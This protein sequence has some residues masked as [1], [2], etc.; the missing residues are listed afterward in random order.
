MPHARARNARDEKRPHQKYQPVPASPNV[1]SIQIGAANADKFGRVQYSPR[2]EDL[3]QDADLH[4]E[5]NIAKEDFDDLWT[6]DLGRV[7]QQFFFEVVL[8]WRQAPPP[9]LC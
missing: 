2:S 1:F 4:V 6:R 8:M 7:P 5:L 3:N 9:R